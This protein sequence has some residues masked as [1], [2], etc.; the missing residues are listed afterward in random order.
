M[1]G[2]LRAAGAAFTGLTL[3]VLA[4]AVVIGALAWMARQPGPAGESMVISIPAGVGSTGVVSRLH[5][6]GIIAHPWLF[7]LVVRFS[8]QARQLQAGEFTVPAGASQV[9][10][11]DIL[12]SGQSIDHPVTIPEGLWSSEIVDLLREH[13][14]LSGTIEAIPP[15]GS[16]LPD[17]YHVVRETPRG[18][19]IDRMQ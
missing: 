17:T 12:V 18:D 11:L 5:A 3:V 4:G 8:G 2:I 10:V 13:P 1:T 15:E 7:H 19:L 6:E 9:E 14:T 16:L